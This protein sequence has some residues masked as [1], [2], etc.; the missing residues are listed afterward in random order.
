LANG[1]SQASRD[2]NAGEVIFI[3]PGF[4]LVPE[5]PQDFS[6]PFPGPKDVGNETFAA[7]CFCAGE[8]MVHLYQAM[9]NPETARG[10]F[11]CTA[12]QADFLF[13]RPD[14][15]PL[16]DDIVDVAVLRMKGPDGLED[17]A[18]WECI[19]RMVARFFSDAGE[20]KVYT[21]N[22]DDDTA[23]GFGLMTGSINHSCQPNAE[24]YVFYNA[25]QQEPFEQVGAYRMQTRRYG[26]TLQA[27]RPIKAGEEITIS[28]D[29]VCD[30]F[31]ESRESRLKDIKE[32]Y[33]FDCRCDACVCEENDLHIMRLKDDVLQLLKDFED[34]EKIPAPQMYRRAAYILDGFAELGVDDRTIKAVWDMCA[35][36]AWL[37]CDMIRAYW[38]ATM[39]FEHGLTMYNGPQAP[40][41]REMIQAY[42]VVE[43]TRTNEGLSSPDK[44]GYSTV[45]ADGYD[46]KQEGLEELMFALHHTN[47]EMYYPCLQVTDGK[48]QEIS[49]NVNK[50]RLAKMQAERERKEREEARAGK[51]AEP[52]E[53]KLHDKSIDE[54]M[55]MLEDAPEESSKTKEKKGKKRKKKAAKVAQEGTNESTASTS[56]AAPT[57]RFCS[58]FT[59]KGG[60]PDGV[61]KQEWHANVMSMDAVRT[62][63]ARDIGHLLAAK[64]GYAISNEC[65]ILSNRRDSMCGRVEGWRDLVELGAVALRRAR[66]HSFGNDQ[67]RRDVLKLADVRESKEF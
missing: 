47:A 28:Y 65:Y 26:M 51:V 42:A 11:N 32:T 35:E 53:E 18:T 67:G 27:T 61:S 7:L 62:T 37:S 31:P 15:T 41:R 55:S 48:V 16:Y 23:T 22:D 10:S 66:T 50:R 43:R 46:T 30:Q 34:F 33:G 8:E 17:T 52:R 54:I 64:D 25:R 21:E 5:S 3:E 45:P 24:L 59:A 60:D 36:R 20:Y 57:A 13:T 56:K 14:R 6:P 2:F 49:R 40:E 4:G 38:F 39:A 58:R 44:Q 29:R 63:K 19:I 12:Q 1:F 9:T